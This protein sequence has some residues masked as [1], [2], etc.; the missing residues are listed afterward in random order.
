VKKLR[1]VSA[2]KAFSSISSSKKLNKT[3]ENN[4]KVLFNKYNCWFGEG[5]SA[6]ILGGNLQ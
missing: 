4:M 6:Q 1:S 5:N 3:T 2:M